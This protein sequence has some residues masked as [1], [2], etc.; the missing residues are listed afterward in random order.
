MALQDLF[1]QPQKLVTQHGAINLA[2]RTVQLVASDHSLP[3]VTRAL[4]LFPTA[5]SPA[6]QYPIT[7]QIA[8]DS[9]LWTQCA[10]P[11]EAYS[12][13]LTETGGQLTAASAAGIFVGCQTIR[14]LFQ[15]QPATLPPLQIVDWPD[16]RYRGFYVESKWGP[17]L[18]T[19]DD[20]K[21][22]IDYMAALKFNSL[23]IG[24]YGCWVVQYG[25]QTTEFMMLPFPEHPALK[26][27]KTLRYYSPAAQ[28]WQTLD[29]LPR[30]AT[31]DFFGDVVAYA[32]ENNITVRPHFNSPG[33]NTLIPRAYPDVSAQ[34]PDG[35]PIGYGFCLSNPRSYE[36]LFELY[37]SVIERY[38]RPHGIDWFHIGLDEVTGYLG[39]DPKRPFEMTAP[40]CQCPQCRDRD[41]GQQLQEYT[42]RVCTHLKAQGI[43]HITLWNDALDSL[44]ALNETL[45]GML[46]AAGVR[47]N[48]IVQWW[49]YNE[50]A[51]VP[52]QELDLRAWVTPMGG[53]WSN[54]FNQGYTAN[55]YPM[56][57]HGQRAGAEGADI[58]CI[59]DSAFDRNYACLAQYS[60][61]Q[62]SGD[63]LYQFKSRYARA[64]LE[65]WLGPALAVEA[66]AK[67]DQVFD[68]MPW[69]G[70]VMASLLYYW[71]TYPN[72]R[73]RGHYPFTVL[74]DLLDEHMRLRGALNS[75]A[76]HART[77]RD[78]FAQANQQAHDP[79][80]EQYRAECD[81]YIGVWETFALL[82]RAVEQY[83][84][85]NGEKI[86]PQ[87]NQALTLIAQA[88]IRFIAVL[89]DLEQIKAAYLLPQ[90]LRDLSIVLVYM[91]QLQAELSELAEGARTGRLSALPPFPELNVNQ[92]DLDPFVSSAQG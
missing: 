34:Y 30:M 11:A 68:E 45:V 67:Y 24:V 82:V 84:L 22:L 35:T 89:A 7:L 55:I 63:D 44:G 4:A 46:T 83:R 57:L 2:N 40:W 90:I 33:H 25:N 21:A 37:D 43:N 65:R 69:T 62:S 10:T 51:L 61:N 91:D 13:E 9:L 86:A 78:L 20:W 53:Y 47:E 52:R 56:L 74:S 72:A 23:G 36:L 66:F 54:L 17:D 26:T 58:Y 73:R 3:L 6:P 14:Q 27:P 19:L 80:L 92:V 76:A 59:Y 88:R 5:S 85:A 79:L 8:P 12:L 42:V 41:H 48:V 28:A 38:L 15:D 39:I 31:E 75:A 50:P 16:F 1:P 64:Q 29:Y 71:H 87:L 81:K 18:M 60:W 70:S 77:A 49:R 32:S